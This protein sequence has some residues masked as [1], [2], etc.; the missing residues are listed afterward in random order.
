MQASEFL[1]VKY[2]YT[3]GDISYL[4]IKDFTDRNSE[5]CDLNLNQENSTCYD[6]F[7]TV[8]ENTLS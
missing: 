5:A 6:L 1:S 4:Y 7:K 3:E 2:Y 8:S